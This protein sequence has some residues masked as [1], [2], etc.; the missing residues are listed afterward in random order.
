MTVDLSLT[1]EQEQLRAAFRALFQRECDIEA[2]RRAEPLGHS[3]EL[4]ARV[5]DLGLADMAV[6]EEAGGG[7]AA[8]LDA[9][10]VCETVGEFLAPVP[11]LETLVASRLLARVGTAAASS[12]LAA[13][14]AGGE[15][16]TIA[17]SPPV[18]G[19]L[20]WVPA[21]AVAGS[22]LLLDGDRLLV[23]TDRPSG[24][25]PTNLGS[26]PVGHR[27]TVGAEVLASGPAAVAAFAAARDDFR[28]LAAALL[29]GAGRRVLDI[30]VAYTKERKAFGVPIASYQSVAH[31]MADLSTALTGARLLSAKAAWAADQ[32]P[33]GRTRLALMAY[34][35]SAEAAE[36]A[37]TEALHFHGGYGF[38]LEYDV[39][40][41]FRRVKA[42]CLLTD[43]PNV[44][45]QH[46]AD[47]LWGP[48]GGRRVA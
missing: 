15:P 42:W 16:A 27:S 34:A 9:A 10:V 31:T 1:E 43:D 45:L 4:W 21:G 37:A 3:P 40:L 2:V 14:V 19:Q 24:R 25:A 44:A 32:D 38:M 11:C 23:T 5:G 13:V 29:C 41:Y 47:E 22:V 36:R 30:A 17:L 26:L 12:V 28:V 8:L 35:F 20:R 46:L 39:Q 18:D 48:A 7:G 6:P 33:I